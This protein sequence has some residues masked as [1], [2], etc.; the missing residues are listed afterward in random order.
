MP[1]LGE[2]KHSKEIGIKG[3]SYR[4]WEKCEL[5]GIPRWTTSIRG[6]ARTKRCKKCGR[7]GWRKE[8]VKIIPLSKTYNPS[9][10]D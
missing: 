2:I 8:K 5:C 4:I 9:L 6:K 3:R 7:V 10:N 1:E